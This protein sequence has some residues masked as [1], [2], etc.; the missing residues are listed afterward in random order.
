MFNLNTIA[1]GSLLW[2]NTFVNQLYIILY[3]NTLF[4]WMII[5]AYSATAS[6]NGVLVSNNEYSFI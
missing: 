1:T 2:E 4:P 3:I 6:F 5:L